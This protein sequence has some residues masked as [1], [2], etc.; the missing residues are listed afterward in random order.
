VLTLPA[1]SRARLEVVRG[2]GHRFLF[3]EPERAVPAIARF[4]DDPA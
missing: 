2:G 3:D 4:L 1:R